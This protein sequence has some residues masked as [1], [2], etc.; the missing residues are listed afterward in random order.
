[1]PQPGHLAARRANDV[2]TV[3]FKGPLTIVGR[4]IEPLTVFD[5]ACRFGLAV[6]VLAAKDYTCTR[7]AMLELFRRYGLPRAIQVDNGPPFG[8][9]TRGLSR[10][11]A[12]WTRLGIHVQFNRP[13]CPQDNPEHERWHRTLQDDLRSFPFRPAETLS[14]R[15]ERLLKIYNTDRTHRSLQDRI[16]AHLYHPSRRR[17]RD[18]APRDYPATWRTLTPDRTGRAWCAGRQRVFGRAFFGQRLGLCPVE[19]GQW[20]VYLDHLLL[21]LIVATDCGGIRPVQL[22]STPSLTS[23][24]CSTPTPQGGEGFALPCTPPAT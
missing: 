1:V 12:E 21:G 10:L 5:L 17:Y 22:R 18:V 20:E 2:W 6:R 11:S 16:P 24:S 23:P 13:A 3:D 4:T 9:G 14:Q 19:P 7:R 8:G 15:I